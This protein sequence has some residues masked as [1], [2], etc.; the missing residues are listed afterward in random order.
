MPGS[1]II[2]YQGKRGTVWRIKFFD[3]ADGRSWKPS[4]RASD[5]G[6]GRR[7]SVP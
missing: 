4:A 1:A 5:G 3:S 7:P 6:L 2:E